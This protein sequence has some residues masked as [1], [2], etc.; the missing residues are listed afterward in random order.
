M[1]PVPSGTGF[2]VELSGFEVGLSAQMGRLYRY[3]RR[4]FARKRYSDEE[5]RK[6]SRC[7]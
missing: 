5:P 3:D 1:S 7:D 4:E 2:F 6:F